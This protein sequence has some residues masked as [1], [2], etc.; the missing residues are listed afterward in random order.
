MGEVLRAAVLC[1]AMDGD[2]SKDVR[3]LGISQ[4]G[5]TEEVPHRGGAGAG[6]QDV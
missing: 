2:S 6:G 5:V 3:W 1:G 4:T